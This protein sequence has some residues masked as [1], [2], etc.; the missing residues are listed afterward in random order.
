MRSTPVEDQEALLGEIDARLL[1]EGSQAL[2]ERFPVADEKVNAECRGP[3]KDSER[4]QPTDRR[5]V[6]TDG[7]RGFESANGDGR[8]CY[9]NGLGAAWR[10]RHPLSEGQ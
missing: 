5:A 7:N 4:D 3:E 8:S 2:D 1:L 10:A 9:A 6:G